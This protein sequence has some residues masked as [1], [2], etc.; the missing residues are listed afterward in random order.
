MLIFNAFTD[1]GACGGPFNVNGFESPSVVFVES[2]PIFEGIF[3]RRLEDLIL[4]D[5]VFLY[6][7]PKNSFTRSGSDVLFTLGNL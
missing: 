6:F 7:V 3:F 1:F 5:F 4:L 2:N